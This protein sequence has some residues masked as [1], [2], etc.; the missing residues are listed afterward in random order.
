MEDA[1]AEL[2]EL[3]SDIK[4]CKERYELL[5]ACKELIKLAD[6][7]LTDR[8]ISPIRERFEYYANAVSSI[9]GER[10]QLDKDLYL[11]YEKDGAFRENEHLSTGQRCVWALCMRLAFIDALFEDEKPF[12]ILDDPFVALDKDNMRKTAQLLYSL[13]DGIQIVYF[14]CH[15]SRKLVT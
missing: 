8:Y 7:N 3:C 15:E 5:L 4:D 13:A 6:N 11:R 14:T 10:V 1:S 12:L 2:R 9:F